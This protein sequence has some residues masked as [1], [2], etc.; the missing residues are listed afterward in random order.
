MKEKKRNQRP[1]IKKERRE[2]IQNV[3]P[4]DQNRRGENADQK[5][6]DEKHRE[7]SQSRPEKNRYCWKKEANPQNE[8][9]R[10]ECFWCDL[11]QKHPEI[12]L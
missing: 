7:R 1:K 5:Q 10:S 8:L 6:I 12:L 4:D 3:P 2:K 11:Q 9:I